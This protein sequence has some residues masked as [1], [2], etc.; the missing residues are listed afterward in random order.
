MR[1]TFTQKS[2][3]SIIYILFL[4]ICFF[5]FLSTDAFCFDSELLNSSYIRNLI[6]SQEEIPFDSILFSCEISENSDNAYYRESWFGP[7]DSQDNT[8]KTN[9]CSAKII[10]SIVKS[11]E[12]AEHIVNMQ[13]K[14]IAV[15]LD[16][17]TN[18][19]DFSSI[20][21]RVWYHANSNSNGVV[22]GIRMIF[23]LNNVVCDVYINNINGLKTEIF[24]DVITCLRSRI[25]MALDGKPY[26]ATVLPPSVEDMKISVEDA[27]TLKRS[28]KSQGKTIKLALKNG[29]KNPRALISKKISTD[30]Y[31]VPFSY[32]A[33]IMGTKS[34]PKIRFI[35]SSVRF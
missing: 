11:S 5:M 14:Q 16:E 6:V 23:I 2:V 1:F 27:W 9:N 33:G 10:V 30:N 20:G 17:V 7:T 4:M 15:T 28:A 19:K 35:F 25:N 26:P 8:D 3:K 31:L 12:Q 32:L 22:T 29:K 21:D 13:L 18:K 24:T 34:K